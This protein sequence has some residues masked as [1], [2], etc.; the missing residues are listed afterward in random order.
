MPK[1]KEVEEKWETPSLE[2]IH[3]VRARMAKRGD[4]GPMALA[5]QKALASKYGLKLV[6]P[7]D[8]AGGK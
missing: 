6:G 1:R 7:R 4:R 8:R 3:R 5:K 2:W